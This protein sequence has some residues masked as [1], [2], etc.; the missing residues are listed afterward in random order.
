MTALALAIGGIAATPAVALPVAPAPVAPVT[1]IPTPCP[2]VH[3]FPSKDSIATIKKKLTKYYGF[4]LTGSGWTKANLKSIRIVWETI[5]ALSCTSYIS[6]LQDKVNGNV[7]LNATSISGYA[8][9]D[10]S[11]TKSGYVSFD[12]TKFNQA[13]ESGDEGRL[14]RLV[15][16][17]LAHVLNSDRYEE[18]SYWKKFQRLYAQEGRFSDYAGSSVTE[19]WADVVGYYVGRCALNN[20]YDTGEFDAY[21]EFVRDNVFDGKEFGPE[22]GKKSDCTVPDKDAATPMPGAADGTWLEGLTGE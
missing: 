15:T 13:I 18:P 22:P 12:F 16:H 8:W 20:P 6:D 11:L 1:G 5:D 9:G 14:T 19:T 21:Y 17:E 10:W 4:E 3:A 2:V 7:G